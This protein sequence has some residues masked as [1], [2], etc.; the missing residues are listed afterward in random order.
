MKGE[1]KKAA[2]VAIAADPTLATVVKNLKHIEQSGRVIKDVG[3]KV[4]RVIA[5]K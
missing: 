2:G 4:I 5:K 3:G 1:M